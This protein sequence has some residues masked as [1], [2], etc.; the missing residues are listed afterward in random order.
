MHVSLTGA[1]I[2]CTI[3]CVHHW[4]CAP[5]DAGTGNQ[6]VT[7]RHLR[8]GH[9]IYASLTGALVV[10]TIDCVHHWFVHHRTLGLEITYPV[11]P[12]ELTMAAVKGAAIA[13]AA[14]CRDVQK[15]IVRDVVT[16]VPFE[17]R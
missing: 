9:L 12:A 4:L 1:L 14:E 13:T 6:L 3:D 11:T 17:V 10:C 16:D 2:V 15:F 7:T 5:Q 8:K